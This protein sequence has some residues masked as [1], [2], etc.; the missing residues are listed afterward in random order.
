MKRITRAEIP[1]RTH[2]KTGNYIVHSEYYSTCL[3]NNSCSSP[4]CN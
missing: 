2:S 3:A 4:G 1:L